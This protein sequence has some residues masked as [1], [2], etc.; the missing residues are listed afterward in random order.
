MSRDR[1]DEAVDKILED[2]AVRYSVGLGPKGGVEFRRWSTENTFRIV[3]KFAAWKHLSEEQRKWA[4]D[5]AETLA[6]KK[7]EDA[8]NE[9]I[10]R[11]MRA[12]R[13]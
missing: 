10:W 8:E 12:G 9:L 6:A 5:T 3:S 4:E 7:R 2:E 1:I 11:Q 13:M